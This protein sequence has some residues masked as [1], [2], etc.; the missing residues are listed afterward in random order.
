MSARERGLVDAS[1]GKSG[2]SQREGLGGCFHWKEW[3]YPETDISKR[4][5]W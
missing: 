5:T 1:T 3:C 4:W 2:V